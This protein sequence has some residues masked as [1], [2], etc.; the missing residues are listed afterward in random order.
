MTPAFVMLPPPHPATLAEPELLAQCDLSRGRS[1]GP[2]GQHRNKVETK[3]TLT[4]EPSGVS[5]HAGERRSQGEN[6]AVAIFR[7]R[8]ALAS[9]VRCPAPPGEIRTDL[10]RSRCDAQG[11]LH[12]SPAHDDYPTLLALAM[13]VLHA[14]AWDPKKASLR[15]CCSASQLIKLIK[16][17]PHAWSTLNTART[18]AGL[19]KL[20]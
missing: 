19:H 12:C 9:A 16:D 10:W 4:H 13:D 18:H 7:L 5:A 11:R 15:L 17:D 6:R 20:Q 2:G 8:L 3:V 1:G 14:A